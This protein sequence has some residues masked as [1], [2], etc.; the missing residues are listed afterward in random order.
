MAGDRPGRAGWGDDPDP[1]LVLRDGLEVERVPVPPGDYGRFYVAMRDAIGHGSR[2]PV[3]AAEA[4]TVMTIIAA[5][6][7]SSA[8]RRAVPTTDLL[9]R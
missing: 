6:I 9:L 1:L 2:V 3:S 5:G 7:E 4:T 8:E